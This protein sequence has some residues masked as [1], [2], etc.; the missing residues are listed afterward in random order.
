[1]Y[2]GIVIRDLIGTEKKD[3]LDKKNLIRSC[4]INNDIKELKNLIKK[5]GVHI[6][7]DGLNWT[8]LHYAAFHNNVAAAKELLKAGLKI[9]D[10]DINNE[11][12]LYIAVLNESIDMIKFL[13]KNNADIFLKNKFGSTI[14]ETV[15]LRNLF[16]K[17]EKEKDTT[18]KIIKI[19]E[20]AILERKKREKEN[21]FILNNE[22]SR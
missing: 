4:I 13:I 1:M 21:K 8:Y 3:N 18:S 22:K 12:P 2:N 16:A 10:L 11:T 7:L 15:K 17:D 19:L 5:N 20:E 14:L 6:K 9:D